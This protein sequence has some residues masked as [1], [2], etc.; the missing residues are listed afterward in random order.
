[1][2]RLTF[3]N[4]ISCIALFVALGGVGYAATHLSP[5]SV[6]TKQL[7]KGAVTP[8]KLSPGSKAALSGPAGPTGARGAEGP[9]GADGARGVEGPRG[10]PGQEGNPGP[11]GPLSTDLKRDLT[12]RGDFNVDQLA[13][14]NGQISGSAISF[15]FSLAAPP[16]V[17]KVGNTP[18]TNCPGSFEDPRAAAGYLCLYRRT[19]SNV[20]SVGV[21]TT[22]FGADLTVV[23]TTTGRFFYEGDWAVTGS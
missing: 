4:V 12:L 21:N 2:R 17:E 8:L 14:A 5:G 15:G 9:R 22:R 6:G 11:V 3:A 1:M 13:T 10:L 20:T 18:T 19:E 23:A 7:R 16:T